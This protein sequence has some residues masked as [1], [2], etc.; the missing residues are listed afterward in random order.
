MAN[1]TLLEKYVRSPNPVLPESQLK[2]LQE[3]L[4]KIEQA[5]SG[6]Y[7]ALRSVGPYV[8]MPFGSL[9]STQDQSAASTAAA[10][11]VTYNSVLD[12]SG[13]S[14]TSG[15]RIKVTHPGIYN[16]QFSFQFVNTANEPAE[17][18]VWFR[19]NGVDIANSNSVF[20]V[21]QKKSAGISGH[22]IGGLNMFVP[23]EPADYVELMWS[24]S[25]IGVT[26]EALPAQTSPTRPATPSVIV[27]LDFLSGTKT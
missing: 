15:S 24:T 5:L 23:I 22:L 20:T 27:T 10:Y 26:I 18:S 17:V 4:K 25:D 7:G 9:I 14:Y 16:I 8:E 13:V 11:A 12:S 19:K 3:E 6:A 1:K 21:H 2:Y